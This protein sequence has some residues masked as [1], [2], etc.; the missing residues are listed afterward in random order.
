MGHEAR[1]RLGDDVLRGVAATASTWYEQR[2]MLSEA[3]EAALQ[4]RNLA[5]AAALIEQI[6]ANPQF[7]YANQLF[8]EGTE[9]HTLRRWLDQL[10]APVLREHPLL[11]LNYAIA[12]LLVLMAGRSHEPTVALLETT[13][14]MAE[15]G[16]RA[17]ENT[18]KLGEV[19]AFRSIIVKQSGE[20]DAAVAL[21]RQALALLPAEEMAWRGASLSTIGTGEHFA[22]RLDTARKLQIEARAISQAIANWGFTRAIIG[23][24]SAVYIE[25]GELHLAAAQTRQTL[26]EARQLGDRDDVGHA[27]IILMT[28]AYQWNMLDDA[29]L[30]ARE[31]FEIGA[32]LDDMAFQ[33]YA[34]LMLAQIEC[35]RGQVVAAKRRVAALID[36]LQALRAQPLRWHTRAARSLLARFDLKTGDLAAAQ[37]WADALANDHTNIAQLQRAREEQL[38]A[39]LLLAQGQADQAAALL[40]RL[41]EQ[42]QRTGRILFGLETQVLLAQAH[43]ARKQL[44]EARQVLLAVLAR[45]AGEG[46]IRLF[47]DEGL[48]VAA[49]LRACQPSIR[50]PA[51]LAYS[52]Q[53]LHAFAAEHPARDAYAGESRH[54]SA[55]DEPLSPQEQRVLSLLAAGRSNPEIAAQLVVSV[56]TV[57]AH[58]KN[59]Y[60][61]LGVRNRL[62]AARRA[63]SRE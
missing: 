31:A 45:A 13:L 53:L 14:Q 61:K 55:L 16:F 50:E 41:L 30:R 33:A 27:Q 5:R 21:A 48:A 6:V 12:L 23:M 62:E 35:A 20:I 63:P 29:E 28:L 42:A 52:Q 9:W 3:I 15:D 34:T 24:L 58:L 2:G 49:L 57:K 46:Y 60:R 1:S 10:P 43:A 38:L 8:S 54:A 44:P 39:R 36:Q 26:A 51:L 17:T 56:N 47:L 18:A 11:C 7:S 32:Q 19:F 4:A 25:Q 22:G 37:R 40:A 59:I